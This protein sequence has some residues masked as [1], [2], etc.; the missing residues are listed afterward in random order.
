[1]S[2]LS[3]SSLNSIAQEVGTPTGVTPQRTTAP[4]GELSPAFP[5]CSWWIET[6][7][8]STNIAFPDINAAYWTTPFSTT[9]GDITI[10][11]DYVDARYFS[12]QVYNE[13]GQLSD[14]STSLAD[15]KIA[16][17]IGSTNPWVTGSYPA[18]TPQSFS[19][20]ISS[21]AT[22]GSNALSMPDTGTIGFIMMRVYIPN[23]LPFPQSIFSASQTPAQ[24]IPDSFA[25]ISAHLP[26]MSVSTAK[27]AAELPTCSSTQ[28]AALTQQAAKGGIA[29][30]AT[31]IKS[32]LKV[33]QRN[34]VPVLSK[35]TGNSSNPPRLKFF[36]TA[37]STTPFPNAESAYAA[38]VYRVL[39]G[40]AVIVRAELPSTPWN[41]Q[42]TSWQGSNPVQWPANGD[43]STYQ[44]RYLSF[45][46]YLD[47]PPYPVVSVTD[48]CATDT[49][50]RTAMGGDASS[51]AIVTRP[52]ER[53]TTEE[54]GSNFIW[55]PA[56]NSSANQVFAIRNMLASTSFAQSVT[57][58]PAPE[59]GAVDPALTQSVMGEYYPI[60]YRCNIEVLKKVGPIKCRGKSAPT[61][62]N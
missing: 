54:V 22:S 62:Q 18:D 38:A 15:Y 32:L 12:I 60:A 25:L 17:A 31:L 14:G 34:P 10:T 43:S 6:S 47:K 40:E 35:A 3:L 30:K 13:K 26:L 39:P 51:I 53:P 5:F 41:T 44:L 33:A 36:R 1:M 59:S 37:S 56:A 55:L 50:I 7:T 27:G 23:S 58:V 57:N 61:A 48:G 2:L 52:R 24:T 19:I 8:T 11:G 46:S 45:C 28:G 20:T 21:Q 4:S 49:Q 16:P 9:G 29:E 42:G